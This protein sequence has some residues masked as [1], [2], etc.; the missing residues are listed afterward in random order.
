L[1]VQ[2]RVLVLLYRL[3]G[4]HGQSANATAGTLVPG[5]DEGLDESQ[6][7]RS[8]FV[9]GHAHVQKLS[10]TGQRGPAGQLVMLGCSPV[11]GRRT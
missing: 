8:T 7:S 11:A 10:Q 1:I 2:G 3:E 4:C 9:Y 6:A 5:G